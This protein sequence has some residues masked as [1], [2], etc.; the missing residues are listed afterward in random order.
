[1]MHR[2]RF[3]LILLLPVTLVVSSCGRADDGAQVPAGHDAATVQDMHRH[4]EHVRL[5]EEAVIRGDIE[6]AQEPARWIAEHKE[7]PGLQSN[8]G[9]FLNDMRTAARRVA[10]ATDVET[11]SQGAAS[12]VASCGSCH[13]ASN[14]TASLPEVTI[15]AAATDRAGHMR[16]H[17][18]AVEL[19][20][21]G[22]AAPSEE[23]WRK[24]AEMLRGSPLA[25][26]DMGDIAKEVQ[27]AE[28][29]VH[30]I[31]ERAVKAGDRDTRV[32]VYGELVS[33]CASCHGMHGKVW[34]PGV[35]RTE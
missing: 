28:G 3:A 9:R 7:S 2:S 26:G 5:V 32:Q 10:D 13:A 17:Q 25:H 15:P 12:L 33:T 16:E 18:A 6:G 31:A 27:A 19:M 8:T 21:R 30:E 23:N 11:A 35:P 34:G 4:V 29:R 22:L 1:M 14:V 20:Y 24:G